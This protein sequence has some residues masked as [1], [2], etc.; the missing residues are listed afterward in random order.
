MLYGLQ[1]TLKLTYTRGFNKFKDCSENQNYYEVVLP[2]MY[3][4]YH[5][6]IYDIML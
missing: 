3:I 5:G 1:L 2:L 4:T 6:L